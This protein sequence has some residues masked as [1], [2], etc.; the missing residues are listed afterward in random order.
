MWQAAQPV[1]R[2]L[3]R[4]AFTWVVG[5]AIAAEVLSKETG[6]DLGGSRSPDLLRAG[7]RVEGALALRAAWVSL[8]KREGQQQVAHSDRPLL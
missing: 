5:Q 6:S 8:E 7:E 3:P 2:K 1:A 4:R